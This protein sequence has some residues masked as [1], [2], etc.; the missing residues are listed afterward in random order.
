MLMA[1]ALG[2]AV[3]TPAIYIGVKA[4]CAVGR[5]VLDDLASSW[6]KGE[7]ILIRPG[8]DD[9]RSLFARCPDLLTSLPAN[10]RFASDAE[11]ARLD[12]ITAPNPV[13]IF[14]LDAPKISRTGR[15]AVV[16]YSYRCNGL[17]GAGYQAR[18][19]LTRGVWKRAGNAKRIWVS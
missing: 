19:K 6:P 11:R 5:A 3:L 17:C 13:T 14:H 2:S 16:S 10:M 15:S 1:L 7:N 12:D 4:D 8:H 18:Y 9:D